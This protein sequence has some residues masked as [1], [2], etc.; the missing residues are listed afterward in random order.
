MQD[1]PGVVPLIWGF[2]DLKTGTW[3]ASNLYNKYDEQFKIMPPY[4]DMLFTP[5]SLEA[6]GVR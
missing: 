5:S 2:F 1:L 4:K 3:I 6:I